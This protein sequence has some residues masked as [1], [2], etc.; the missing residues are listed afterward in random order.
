MNALSSSNPWLV[1]NHGGD[2][3]LM[4]LLVV[5]GKGGGD[6]WE[7]S[8]ACLK[9]IKNKL[10]LVRDDTRWWVTSRWWLLAI[11]GIGDL[12]LVAPAKADGGGGGLVLW[13]VGWVEDR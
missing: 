11:D 9:K 4:L 1:P 5:L 2:V 7:M 10:F 8:Y 6:W 13:L 3:V 12:L